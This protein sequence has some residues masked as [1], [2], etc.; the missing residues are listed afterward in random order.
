MN[1][2]NIIQGFLTS[3]QSESNLTALA[4][5][6]AEKLDRLENERIDAVNQEWLWLA[7][8]FTTSKDGVIYNVPVGAHQW[9]VVW[10]ALNKCTCGE[11]ECWHVASAR[12]AKLML[13]SEQNKESK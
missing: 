10:L 2:A 12:L 8:R 3:A 9:Q 13:E 11:S 7:A 1:T 4:E 5:L 6:A